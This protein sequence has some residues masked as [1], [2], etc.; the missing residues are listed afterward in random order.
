MSVWTTISSGRDREYVVLKHTLRGV[1]HTINGIKF[2]NSYAVV[3]KDSKT[4]RDLKRIPV[5]KASEEFPLTFLRKLSFITRPLDVKIVYGADV[6][7]Q[8]L[9]NL[10]KELSKE[11]EEKKIEQEIKHI[12]E[13]KLCSYKT[14]KN[15]LCKDKALEHSPSGYCLRHILEEPRLLEFGIE[16]PKFI[17]KKEKWAMKEKVSEE[18]E[19]L[20]KEGKF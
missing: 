12:V 2:R 17:P 16:V 7:A 8:Y 15:D 5:L 11:A 1:N 14:V 20:K 4:Y 13:H 19:S 6:F 9:K 18:L 10:E 3:E